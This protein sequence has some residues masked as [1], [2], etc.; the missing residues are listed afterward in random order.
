MW[1]AQVFLC[2]L[3]R[4]R[5]FVVLLPSRRERGSVA[6]K[7]IEL[8]L[9]SSNRLRDLRLHHSRLG[10][11]H[12]PRTPQIPH[13]GPRLHS[14]GSASNS[15]E[16][17]TYEARHARLGSRAGL[18]G[19]PGQLRQ[20]RCGSIPYRATWQDAVEI[21]RYG[22]LTSG[23]LPYIGLGSLGMQAACQVGEHTCWTMTSATSLP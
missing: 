9:T 2:S 4:G 6:L 22:N 12:A 15:L 7:K 10:P 8:H 11:Q 3:V 16:A 18:F 17:P 13:E 20:R 14:G 19:V 1:R 5:P 23:L 21:C